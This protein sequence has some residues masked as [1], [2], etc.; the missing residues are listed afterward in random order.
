MQGILKLHLIVLGIL[1]AGAVSSVAADPDD[2][3][4]ALAIFDRAL[5]EFEKSRAALSNWQYYQTLTTQQ[6]DSSGNVYIA[7]TFNFVIRVLNTQHATITVAGVAINA[8]E[9]GTVAGKPGKSCTTGTCGLGGP[10]LGAIASH[11][12]TTLKQTP[13]PI[14]EWC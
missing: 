14:L 12:P 1:I 5:A 11:S 10:A 8:G 2:H 13:T 4:S 6:L 9:L 3:L 7:D